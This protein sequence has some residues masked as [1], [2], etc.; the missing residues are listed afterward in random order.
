MWGMFVLVS[1]ANGTVLFGSSR[2]PKVP[3]LPRV[4]TSKTAVRGVWKPV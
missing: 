2:I 4:T 1:F 3:E